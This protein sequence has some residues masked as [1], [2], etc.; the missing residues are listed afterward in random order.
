MVDGEKSGVICTGETGLTL[1]VFEPVHHERGAS[2]LPLCYPVTSV[3][4]RMLK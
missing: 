1:A 2:T 3:A 4:L